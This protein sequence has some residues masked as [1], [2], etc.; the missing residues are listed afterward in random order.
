M[1]IFNK[2]YFKYLLLLLSGGISVFA[3]APFNFSF[4]I[5]FSLLSFLWVINQLPNDLS[6]AKCCKYGYLYGCAFFAPQ[7][8]WIFYSINNVIQAG[9]L[10][11]V[12][13]MM[14]CSLFLASYIVVMLIVYLRLKTKSLSFNFLFLFPSVWVLFEWLRGWLILDGYPWSDV[15]YTQVS[16]YIFRGYFR[17]VGEYG[18]SWLSVS[19]IGAFGL[20]VCT[21]YSFIT[22]QAK[23]LKYELGQSLVYIVLVVALG[24]I[25]APIQYTKPYGEPT[26]IALIQG[27]IA[28]GTKWG[29]GENLRVYEQAIRETKADIIMMPETAIAQFEMNLPKGYLERITNQA[30]TNGASLILGIPLILNKHYDYV[31]TAMLVTSPEHPYYAK[32]HLVPYGEYMPAKWLGFLYKYLSLPMVGFTPGGKYQAPIETKGQKLA[33]NICYENGFATELIKAASNSTLMVNL[34]DMVWFGD[35][36][37]MDQHLQLSQ[38]RAIENERYFIQV[39]NTSITAVINQDGQIKAELPVFTR[40]ILKD[41]VQGRVG[42]TPFE[43]IGNSV[44]ISLCFLIILGTYIKRRVK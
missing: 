16:T 4:L 27:N 26:T 30:K 36:I 18:V 43:I 3:Y 33:F 32:Y 34:S 28:A 25:L 35:S 5:I 8:Y 29:E 39:T 12:I 42:R 15:G 13:A 41:S 17:L 21:L 6:K 2:T 40:A 37:A 7:I 11:A 24:A 10:V 19:L 9:H 23:P 31:N 38:A 14:G 1:A 22:K 20:I 44:I